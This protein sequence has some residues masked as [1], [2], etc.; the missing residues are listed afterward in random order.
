[1]KCH[2]GK[3][4]EM[5]EGWKKRQKEGRKRRKQCECGEKTE[6][7]SHVWDEGVESEDA[8]MQYACTVCGAEK[9][10]PI[11]QGSL[12]AFWWIPVIAYIAAPTVGP[13][14]NM[15]RFIRKNMAAYT[16]KI[17]P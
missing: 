6:E 7:E 10:E 9:S 13:F 12:S 8:V 5:E 14:M 16:A 11:P 4:R 1:M 3:R 2:D 15:N 17:C